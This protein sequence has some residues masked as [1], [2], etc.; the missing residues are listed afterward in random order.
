M[1]TLYPARK[2]LGVLL[3]ATLLA[4]MHSLP[5]FAQK[6]TIT[7]TVK[8]DDQT[9]LPGVAVLE[10]GTT[11]GSVTD[12]DGK[13]SIS[14]P[15]GAT[16]VFSF[17]GMKPQEVVVAN[18]TV[19]DVVLQS[20]IT[21]LSEV[22][23][24]GY[25]TMKKSDLTGSVVSVSGETLKAVPVSTVGE[26]LTGRLAGVQ[27]TTTEGSPDADIRIRVRGGGSITQD[28]SPLYI[29][30]G[31]PVNNISDIAPSD[32]QSIDV[33]KDASSTAIYG[34]R[35]AN[36][37][38]IITTRSGKEG[39]TSVSYNAFGG[40]KRIANTLDVLDPAD[41]VKWQYEYAVLEK[42]L[43]SY[44]QYFGNYGDRDLYTNIPSNNW[45]R[46][47][48]G[49][50]GSVFSNDLNVRGGTD[51]FSYSANYARFQEK[52]IMIGSDF[53]RDNFT[54][55][56]NN[57]P[58][59]KVDL[60]FSL[61]Y[62]DTR[63]S[64]GGA[65]EQNE[66]SSA[67]SRLKHSV[68]YAPIPLSGLTTDDTDSEI[69]SYL[70]NP[71]VST[72]DNDRL[73]RRKN[74][75]IAGSF[76]WNII[77]NLQFKTELGLDNY[78][79]NDN[80]FYG[81]TTYYVNNAPS[82]ENQGLPASI[83][84]D[85]KEVR[86][87]NTNTLNYD[88][89]KF[90]NEKH[91]LK[92]LLGHELL[93][94]QFTQLTSVLHGYPELFTSDQAFRL[95]SQASP[96]ATD[97][98]YFPDDKLVSFFGRINYDVMGRYLLNATYRADASSRFAEGNRWGYFPS[99]AAAW[100]ISEEAFMDGP[101]SWLDLLKFRASFGLAGNNNIPTGQ[102]NQI[103]VSNAT[104]WINGTEN[105]W[106]PSKTMANPELKWES[107]QTRNI[108]LDFGLLQSRLTGTVEAYLN[109][110][111][112]LLIQFPVAG[113]GYDFQY[114]NMGSTEN[115]GLEASL[116]YI[117]VEKANAGL[118]F[119][120]NIG[121]NRNR[122]KSLGIMSDFG[123]VTNWASTEIGTDYWIATGGSVGAMFGYKSDG[124]Y[125][126]SDFEGYDA[127]ANKWILKE[128]VTTNAAVI[129]ANNLRPGAMKLLDINGDNEITLADRTV[130]GNAN[131]KHTG[132]V[133]INGYAY[134][135]D[136]TAAFNWSY[137]NSIYN[138]NKIE[139]TTSSPR[140]Q[141]RNLIDIMADGNRWTN[142]DPETGALVNDP[143]LLAAMNANTTMWSPYMGRFVFSDWAVED[144]S[145]LRLNTLTL[146]YTLPSSLVKKAR[147]QS[148]RFYLT[149][150]N[151][152]II[153]NYTGFDPEVS[154]RRRTALTPGVDYSAYPRS[155]QIVAGL[156]LNF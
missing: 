132:G 100:K 142:I 9:A 44:E 34:S 146:G 23:V 7:G 150:Y 137:G 87:R 61:R 57:K 155:R 19:I 25:G 113:T 33:L 59:K 99:V 39:R 42:D 92:L 83:L 4:F 18:Q 91:S 141:Y 120:F 43:P 6:R 153:T 56:L 101:R 140:Y 24:V 133:V 72:A 55:K 156:N 78:N 22:V 85:R 11:N 28:N 71:I 116:N 15:D 37:V 20:D 111:R 68:T 94:S 70:V 13:Y 121:F 41:Y 131:P 104:T 31:F 48:Y 86:M 35:G 108:G 119:T 38:V 135:F 40:S 126:V 107:T 74:Y 29:V 90:L 60:V 123:E 63:I 105:F 21:Q 81:L 50:T 65:N 125:E 52:A 112:D 27:V 46:Q 127:A 1:V 16:L 117:A 79:Y 143:Q 64:G 88:F 139:Y 136:L 124:R 145:F 30:D 103:F 96:Q 84:R 75:N 89:R 62:A 32:I 47:V 152:F 12:I 147:I 106:A 118:N 45:Q 77:Q 17:I 5:A 151:V 95:T 109:D 3:F 98:F 53:R 129:G 148:L 115:K 54:L 138:A 36:G 80:R 144:G 51:K 10:K 2:C 110:T 58:N 114:R 154:T 82:S 76:G 93:H 122:I 102:M 97:N 73:Q 67:D 149:G 49:R 14:A 66:V 128:G 69:A 130:I 26:Q 134:G 8:G